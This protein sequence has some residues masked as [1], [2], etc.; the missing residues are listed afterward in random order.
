MAGALGY[1]NT[2]VKVNVELDF[3]RIEK[4]NT[5]YDPESQVAR[6]EQVIDKE[7]QTT[8][9]LSFPYVNMANKTG[10]I[11]T[12]YEIVCFL[13]NSDGTDEIGVINT[14]VFPKVY[15]TRIISNFSSI[16]Y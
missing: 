2:K 13:K 12:N 15:E 16:Y 4:T 8:D 3:T 7:S 10:N 9:S 1:G 11:V 14:D 6:S 5:Q